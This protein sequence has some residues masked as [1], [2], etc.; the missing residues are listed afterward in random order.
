MTIKPE[1]PYNG[2]RYLGNTNEMKVHDLEN[3]N[4]NCQIDEIKYE[5]IKMY[6]YHFQAKDNGFVDCDYCF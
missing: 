3:E 6:D 4:V 2:K 5:H 1:Y